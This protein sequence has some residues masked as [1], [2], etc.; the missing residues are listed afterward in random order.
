MKDLR[1]LT[2]L[3]CPIRGDR[4]TRW[5]ACAFAAVMLAGL[6]VTAPSMAGDTSTSTTVS[7]GSTSSTSVPAKPVY[8][9]PLSGLPDPRGLTKHHSAITIK[10][11][12]TYAARP[13]FGVNEAD[14]VYEEI[15]EGGITRLAAVFD[16][17]LPTVVG[18]IRSVRRTDREIVFP[19][20]GVFA[21]S[22]GA[23]Y[24][25]Q[26]IATAP[27]KFL[28]ESTSGGAMFRDSKRYPPHN[29]VGN[30]AALVKLA[31]GSKPPR[32][33][34]SYRSHGAQAPGAKV[35]SFTVGFASGYA[36]SYTWDQATMSWNR[37]IFGGPDL[38]AS[39]I[40]LSPKNVIVMNVNYKGG[41]G[42]IGAEAV[43]TGSGPVE[44]F[45]DGRVE[46]G[47]W[48]RASLSRPI[49]YKNNGRVIELTPGQTWVELL[50]PSERATI[51]A[52]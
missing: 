10:I 26:S 41:V 34:F 11:D 51:T 32:E 50:D 33:I 27:V 46:R 35:R 28:D 9:A 6:S 37:Y 17:N 8:V 24:A 29:L 20:R 5:R 31:K 43:L 14:V 40:Q 21:C 22:G 7:P 30:A 15:V 47:T 44:I 12:N 1:V 16:S 48:S 2:L 18:P 19:I 38:V 36:T 45:T 25:L 23:Q 39:G 52:N 49:A 42:V 4:S 3:T 13:Q